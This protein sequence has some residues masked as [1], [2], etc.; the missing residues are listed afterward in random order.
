MALTMK[1]P[2][3]GTPSVPGKVGWLATQGG[4]AGYHTAL[5]LRA[6]S[7]H[8]A[9][10]GGMA[11]EALFFFKCSREQLLNYL[12]ENEY[13]ELSYISYDTLKFPS[14]WEFSVNDRFKPLE[15]LRT[16]GRDFPL[17]CPSCTVLPKWPQN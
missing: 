11:G 5:A 13:L 15:G 14:Y 16:F 2:I 7:Q 8:S 9:L 1:A 17:S 10:L 12:L 3:L 6:R 4:K